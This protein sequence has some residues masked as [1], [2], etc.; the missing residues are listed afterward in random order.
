MQLNRFW[1]SVFSVVAYLFGVGLL[2]Y[3]AESVVSLFGLL[4]GN[5]LVDIVRA[6]VPLAGT[7]LYLD[8]RWG[9]TPEHIG[10]SRSAQSMVWAVGGLVVGAVAAVLTV[11]IGGVFGD[12]PPIGTP[13][14]SLSTVS[15]LVWGLFG[16]FSV[17]LIFRGTVISRYRADLTQR[18]VL[19]AAVLTP[20]GWQ[21]IQSIFRLGILP[22]GL[23]T[24]WTVPLSVALTLIFLRTESVWFS[25]GIRFG[26]VGTLTVL[27][28]GGAAL[29]TGGLLVWGAVAAVLFALDWRRQ[30]G[31][32]RRMQPR[33]G[34]SRSRGRTVRGPWGPH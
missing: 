16:A 30:Q 25:T 34:S 22:S 11:L 24:A 2:L 4:S 27:G 9:W 32:P 14:L 15:L 10:L 13:S 21:L 12:G 19:L 31:A 1:A 29:D 33:R 8:W 26:T 5:I 18:E 3:I 17:E 20:F 28:A 23:T 6:L 7:L